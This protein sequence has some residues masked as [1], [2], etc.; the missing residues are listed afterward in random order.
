MKTCLFVNKAPEKA[1]CQ[2]FPTGHPHPPKPYML[3]KILICIPCNRHQY[4][5]NSSFSSFSPGFFPGNLVY[6]SDEQG[7][8]SQQQVKSME[9][10][11]QGFWT[12][13]DFLYRKSGSN[14]R[15]QTKQLKIFSILKTA[16]ETAIATTL[17]LLIH[18]LYMLLFC[19]TNA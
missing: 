4:V 12:T 6:G 11:N 1:M 10:Y 14:H 5:T 15:S 19:C 18:F 16:F 7:E 9:C 2:L 17:N 13:V 3:K 8:R